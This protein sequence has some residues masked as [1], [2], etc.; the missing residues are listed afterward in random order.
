MVLLSFVSNETLAWR[1]M[2]MP[3][4]FIKGRYLMAKD[5]NGNDSI[6]NLHGFGQTYSPYFNDYA[7]CK[8]SNGQ[9]NWG[10]THDAAACV[11]WNSEQIGKMLD[12]GWM[13]NWLRLHMDP[14]WSNDEAKVKYLR[15]RE[16]IRMLEQQKFLHDMIDGKRQP[17]PVIDYQ[18]GSR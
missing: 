15:D 8:Y 11:K 7:W 9:V 4:L 3:E 5:V 1:G 12:A 13:V 2:R 17:H 6:V 18:T 16:E 14:H 10:K